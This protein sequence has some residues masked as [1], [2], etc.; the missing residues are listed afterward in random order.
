[1]KVTIS[2]DRE[3]QKKRRL[4]KLRQKINAWKA[5]QNDVQRKITDAKAHG[6]PTARL[7]S[8]LVTLKKQ[9][10]DMEAKLKS[11]AS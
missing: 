10:V 4:E 2:V 8:Q 6:K 5:K 1:M 9:E 7:E 11:M 3:Y